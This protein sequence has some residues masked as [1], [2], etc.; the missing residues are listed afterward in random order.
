MIPKIGLFDWS[1]ALMYLFI[2][3][4][5]AILYKRKKIKTNPEYQ[6]FLIGLTAKL[7]G[8]ISFVLYSIYYK[9][10]GDST[11]FFREA[12]VLATYLIEN[13]WDGFNL[14]FKSID[15]MK[16]SYFANLLYTNYTIMGMGTWGIV[17]I[18]MVFY[19]A[20]F[21]SYLICSLLFTV[22]SFYFLWLGYSNLC[23]LYPTSAKMLLIP[24]FLTPTAI[25]WGSGILKD[26]VC[27]G[28]VGGLL[29]SFSN[30]FIFKEKI[31]RSIII[32]LIGCF[33]VMLLKPYLL[34]VLL[35]CLFIWVQSNFKNLIKGSF[36]RIIFTPI[37]FLLLVGTGIALFQKISDGAGKYSAENVE[38]TLKG[39]HSWHTYLAETRDQSGYT[40]GEIEFTPLGI[41]QKV[42]ASL[43]VTFFRPYLWEIRNLPML[44]GAIEGFLL[45]L[46]VLYLLITLKFRFFKLIVKNK[47]VFFM[48]LF[49][50]IFGVVVG[51][52]SYNFGALSRYKIP[53]TFMMMISLI[54]IYDTSKNNLKAL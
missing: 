50:L 42:P 24:F 49:A 44:L 36:I 27:I 32:T 13:P 17:R 18:A 15:E 51:L 2:I 33:M 23:R 48:L 19:L 29:Y 8:G 25:L 1:L 52:S 35:P 53:A 38:Q 43:N 54:I 5:F 4:F 45:L 3:Y 21:E 6:Y 28:V 26:T 22:T 14:I 34:Y 12:S 40:F 46:T 37:L 31:L 11:Y 7:I 30:V 16:V 41:L 39:F 10:G 9:H 20:S 47:E